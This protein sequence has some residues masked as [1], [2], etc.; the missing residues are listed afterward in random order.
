MKKI[1]Y[2]SL[3]FVCIVFFAFKNKK[4]Y[5]SS[6]APAGYSG[7]SGFSCSSCHSSFAPNS[8]G[9]NV[10]VTGLPLSGYNPGQTYPLSV[11]VTHG[12]ADRTRW[13]FV[14]KA[15]NSANSPVGTFSAGASSA[16]ISDVSSG[17][18]SEIGHAPAV[19]TAA[20]NTY[21]FTGISW[22]APTTP[23]PS[24]ATISFYSVGN[25]A[26]NNGSTNGDFIYTNIYAGITLPVVLNF[27]NIAKTNDQKAILSWQTAQE[28][29]S[30]HFEIQKSFDGTAFTTIGRLD[31]AGNSSLPKDYSFTDASNTVY[32]KQLYYRLKQEDLNGAV[33]YSKILPIRFKQSS[34]FISNVYPNPGSN[35]TPIQIQI[36]SNAK[37]TVQLQ[38]VSYFGATLYTE[39][40]NVVKGENYISLPA[41]ISKLSVGMHYI[42]L[43][44]EEE[45]Q[46]FALSIF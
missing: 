24:D 33:T 25:A 9:G 8:G 41:Y 28:A 42:K 36:S 1:I 45:Q 17:D 39:K 46:S 29:N 7:I 35:N 12:S 2:V 4:P 32:D 30:S 15:A 11:T 13:G 19:F 5:F 16:V 23:T 26:N 22:K 10:T 34:V 27:I 20:G 14:L 6:L 31:A 44:N 18:F 37:T 21:T 40:I 38:L 43:K 3:F